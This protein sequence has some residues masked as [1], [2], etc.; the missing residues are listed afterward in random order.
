MRFLHSDSIRIFNRYFFSIYCLNQ[1]IIINIFFFNSIYVFF[2]SITSMVA[3]MFL[4]QA[5]QIVQYNTYKFVPE[6][7]NYHRITIFVT[8]NYTTL[9]SVMICK[10]CQSPLKLQLKNPMALIQNTFQ[11]Q[12]N[13]LFYTAVGIYTFLAQSVC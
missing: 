13:R 4:P 7:I 12:W 2:G 9:F 5:V 3:F 6:N 8:N 1:C 11:Q 10:N